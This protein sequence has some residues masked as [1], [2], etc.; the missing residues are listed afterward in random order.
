MSMVDKVE[1]RTSVEIVDS[2]NCTQCCPRSCCFPFGRKITKHDHKES[3]R[4]HLDITATGI[5]V[6]A[7]SQPRL[8]ESGKWEVTI[9]GARNEVPP[10]TV[11]S[12]EGNK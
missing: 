1:A 6:I 2:C 5:K 11:F 10:G 4:G 9:D 3:P 12:V 8:T 7:D